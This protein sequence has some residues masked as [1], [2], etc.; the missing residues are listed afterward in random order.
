MVQLKLHRLRHILGLPPEEYSD[1]NAVIAAHCAGV[2]VRERIDLFEWYAPDYL[3][4]ITQQ[5]V[6][7]NESI[8]D[9]VEFRNGILPVEEQK[10]I[11]HGYHRPILRP[12]EHIIMRDCLP[13]FQVCS[14]TEY[15]PPV[16]ENN[17][18]HTFTR[19][20]HDCWKGA[21]LSPRPVAV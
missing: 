2:D 3:Y 16:R 1:R 20:G 21:P 7:V 14:R 9:R 11:E 8:N 12:I 18:G 4:L 15:D 6:L 5:V 10:W 13:M 17:D 19:R